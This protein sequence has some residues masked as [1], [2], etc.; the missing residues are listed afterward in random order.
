MSGANNPMFGK[1]HTP[2][3]RT[4]MCI[5]QQLVDRSGENNPMFGRTGPLNPMYGKSHTGPQ[6]GSSTN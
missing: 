3:S 6:G 5:N 1:T 4:Q 2:E